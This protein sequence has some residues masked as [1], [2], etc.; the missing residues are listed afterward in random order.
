M[1]LDQRSLEIMCLS[2]ITKSA[3]C[4]DKAITRQITKEHFV[5]IEPNDTSSYTQKMYDFIMKYW[6]RSGGSLLTGFVLESS[7]NE[8][9]TSENIRRK[10]ITLWDEVENFDFDENDFHEVLFLLKKNNGL[11]TLTT[12]FEET[13]DLLAN[14]DLK[15]TVDTIQKKLDEI[16]LE[17]S[18]NFTDKQNFDVSNS[19]EYFKLE[20]EKRLTQPELFKGI[21][22]GLGNIDTKTF[23]WMPGQIVVFMAPSSGGKSVMLLNSAVHAHRE[24]KKNVLYMSFEMNS[25]LCLLRHISLSFE[26]PYS[27]LKDNNLAPDE[28][29]DIINGLDASKDGA[30]FEYDVKK[31]YIIEK[32]K[33]TLYGPN[34]N[35]IK[36]SNIIIDTV[37]CINFDKLLKQFHIVHIHPNNSGHTSVRNGIDVP[38]V[39]EF[40]FLRRDRVTDRLPLS[41]EPHILDQPNTQRKPDLVLP[42]CWRG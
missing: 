16:Q 12:A 10:Y 31:I 30:Y 9:K 25:W 42:V 11:R 40:T 1:K 36:H 21:S 22:C 4:M 26:I 5:H 8:G 18:D 33:T 15:S 29:K 28:L 19:A 3:K 38:T 2:A 20:Y 7:M 37:S 14:G 35:N 39:L 6:E 24:C 32:C 27:A 17:L 34:I 23:G 41:F 13:S